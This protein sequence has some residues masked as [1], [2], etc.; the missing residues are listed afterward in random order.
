MVLLLRSAIRNAWPPKTDTQVK[1]DG[2]L[3]AREVVLQEGIYWDFVRP[4][5]P[6]NDRVVVSKR[7]STRFY[8]G[9]RVELN[10][11]YLKKF[12]RRAKVMNADGRWVDGDTVVYY[13]LPVARGGPGAHN[14]R[15]EFGEEMEHVAEGNSVSDPNVALDMLRAARRAWDLHLSKL[16]TPATRLDVCLNILATTGING[17]CS[18]LFDGKGDVS[19]VVQFYASMSGSCA[20]NLSVFHPTYRSPG[21]EV[22]SFSCGW[23]NGVFPDTQLGYWI[24]RYMSRVQQEKEYPN[25]QN[26][27]CRYESIVKELL[28]AGADVGPFFKP[29]E[30]SGDSV[31]TVVS[32]IRRVFTPTLYR[33][34]LSMCEMMRLYL[35]LF[36]RR[37]NDNDCTQEL[38]SLLDILSRKSKIELR[39]NVGDWVECNMRQGWEGG[40]VTKQWAE[41]FTYEVELANGT[42]ASA[43]FD[44]NE[45]IRRPELRFRVGDRVE[46]YMDEGWMPGTVRKHWSDLNGCPYEVVL[47]KYKTWEFCTA[48]CDTDGY[49][50]ALNE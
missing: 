26:S 40:L 21:A 45:F 50:R 41:G 36:P 31:L 2:S 16:P 11:S 24:T 18:F 25:L 34:R 22:Y 17:S 10:E 38:A 23:S 3:N 35:R 29:L 20:L 44:T 37:D 43:P 49:I 5:T 42:M 6:V 28:D 4:F 1:Q 8:A 14:F 32:E 46:C 48:P 47:D 13:N 15:L 19:D 7:C 27:S 30:H 9:N 33:K 39:F 12:E